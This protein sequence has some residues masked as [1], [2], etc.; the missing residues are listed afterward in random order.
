MIGLLLAV[1]GA[2]GVFLVYTA[3]ALGWTGIG[4]SPVPTVRR[5]SRRDRA[6]DWLA[7]AGLD[8]AEP[9]EMS[10]VVAVLLL[11]GVGLGYVIFGGVVAPVAAGLTAATVPVASARR[12]RGHR[13]EQARD[14]W[15]RMI[16]EVRVQ[17]V[18]LGRSIPQALLAVGARGPEE[19]RPAFDAAQREWLVSTD[20]DRTLR[21][22]RSRLADPTADAVCETLLVAHEVGGSEVDRRLRALTEDR[23]QDLQGRKDARAR[24]AG[25]RFARL[26][27]LGVPVGMALVGLSIGSGRVAYATPLGQLGVAVAFV[28]TGACWL[29]AGR[30]MRLPVEERV[31]YDD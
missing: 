4:V 20:F 26:F 1:V 10:A 15:P 13:I 17:T 30:I 5:R 29:W 19:L 21:V 8:E 11:V 31:F 14:A 7:Q 25:A 18:N 6:R 22:L 9:L 23:I 24:Q 2:Y 28:L 3:L 27:T 16:E 12:R